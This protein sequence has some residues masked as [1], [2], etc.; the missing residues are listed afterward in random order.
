MPALILSVCGLKLCVY[1]NVEH[2]HQRYSHHYNVDSEAK[3]MFNQLIDRFILNDLVH[4]VEEHS[5]TVWM[6]H[7]LSSSMYLHYR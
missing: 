6:T 3:L 7:H 2:D 4:V 1:M 5:E